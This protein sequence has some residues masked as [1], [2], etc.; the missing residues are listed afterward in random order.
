MWISGITQGLMW[1]SYDELGFLEY[2]FI[3]SV[4]AIAPLRLI[5]AIGGLLFLI[6]ALVMAYNFYKTIRSTDH[7]K[8]S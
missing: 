6:G 7:A 4:L 3:E 5:R 1:K 2:S 8:S